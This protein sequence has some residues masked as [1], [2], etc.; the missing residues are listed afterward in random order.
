MGEIDFTNIAQWLKSFSDS[1]VGPL[2]LVVIPAAITAYFKLS[3]GMSKIKER[4]K[5]GWHEKLND[6][7]AEFSRRVIGEISFF[8]D[9]IHTNPYCRADQILYLDIEN[10][11]VGPSNLHSMFISLQAESTGVS[12]CAPKATSV[13]RI[14]Y[15][16]MAHWCNELEK[17]KVLRLENIDENSPYHNMK[18]HADAKSAIVV[19]VYTK[20][21]WLAGMVVFNY[22]DEHFNLQDN[23][24]KCEELI[25]SIKAF[26]E[27]Q[28]LHKEMARQ[29]W[30]ASHS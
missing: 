9:G 22:F 15:I 5:R 11:I 7:E 26:V 8:I 10:G 24:K 21:N 16:E 19:P 13:Q 30:I 27:G 20:E 14:P 29:N 28:F 6:W 25:H 18:V 3:K 17:E 23:T 12:R 1:V 4:L 2:V